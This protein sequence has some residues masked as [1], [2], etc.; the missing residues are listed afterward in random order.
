MYCGGSEIG[1]VL[2]NYTRR[3]EKHSTTTAAAA[4]AAVSGV[5]DPDRTKNSKQMDEITLK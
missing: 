1:V 2:G 3:N 5:V 4:A